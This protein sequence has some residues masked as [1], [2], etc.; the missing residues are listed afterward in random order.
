MIM[1]T[2]LGFVAGYLAGSRDGKD[3]AKRL[4]ESFEAIISSPEVRRMA[5]EAM[6]V[7]ESAARRA[8]AGRSFGSLS[9][10]VGTVTDMLAHRAGALGKGNRAA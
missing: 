2:I 10:T 3:G 9:D 7:A 5:G 4:R 8:T 1:E 6:T